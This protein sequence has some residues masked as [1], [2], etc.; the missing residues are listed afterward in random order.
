MDIDIDIVFVVD[1]DESYRELLEV[2]LHAECGVD[3][4]HT[5]ASGEEALDVLLPLPAALLPT[6]LLLDYHMPGMDGIAFLRALRASP[7]R[8][9]VV[10]ISQAAGAEERAAC[11]DE[12]ALEIL[13]KPARAERLG[14]ELRRVL[15]R[16][17]TVRRGA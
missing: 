6:M 17:R 3:D 4:V 5:F 12:G 11:L 16:C 8:V 10:V 9:P 14:P 1:D 7:V 13:Q 2:M 15:A